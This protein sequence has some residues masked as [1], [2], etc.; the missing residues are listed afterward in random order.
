MATLAPGRFAFR[1]ETYA[2]SVVAILCFGAMVSM[3]ERQVINLLVEPLKADLGISDTQISI[4]QGF[5]F[6]IFYAAMALPIGRIIDAKS[7]IGVI[8]WGTLIFSAATF[9]CGLATSFLMLVLFRT[10]VGVGEATL[11]PA[12]MSLLGDYFP[13]EKLGRAVGL[14]IGSTYAGSGVALIAIGAV[15]GWLAKHPDINLPLIGVARDWQIAFMLAALPGFLFVAIMWLVK[16]PPRST[17]SGEDVGA[18]VP[19]SETFA[20][21]GAHLGTVIPIFLGIPL[22]AAANFGIN[23]WAPTFFIRTHGWDASAIGPVYGLII[24]ACGSGGSVAGGVLNDWLARRGVVKSGL[25]VPVVS[26]LCAVPF[27]AAFPLVAG[28]SQ[29]IALLIPAL[30]FGAMPFGA[31]TAGIV[32][33]AP[34]RMRGQMV[35]IYM[36]I[37]TLIGT[38]GG[39]WV[40][41]V[42]TDGVLGDPM[43]LGQSLAVV[44]TALFLAGAAII[45][46]CLR[47]RG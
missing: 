1:S 25:I 8:V 23:N 19:L 32:N 37:A 28:S 26:S 39:P 18:P 9:F 27:V 22:L 12:G 2:W 4:L 6:A 16:E 33:F 44:P 3:I 35:A 10:L 47:Q 40:V 24:I 42:W 20:Y 45:A 14:F 11:V 17:N 29:S 38:G 34:N 15:L 41:A 13:P 36:L 7:R 43:K 30:F 31:G 46:T 21:I 5:A